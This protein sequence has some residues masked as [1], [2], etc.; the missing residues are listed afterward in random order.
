MNEV[1]D[2]ELKQTKTIAWFT[3]T[4]RYI[5]H[6][7]YDASAFVCHVFF[8]TDTL[9]S[10]AFAVTPP[11]PAEHWSVYIIKIWFCFVK[12]CVSTYPKTS[13][14]ICITTYRP[15][16]GLGQRLLSWVAAIYGL[17]Y[18]LCKEQVNWMNSRWFGMYQFIEVGEKIKIEHESSQTHPN[19]R[20]CPVLKHRWDWQQRE[21]CRLAGTETLMLH[22]EIMKTRWHDVN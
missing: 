18:Q 22:L 1:W 6:N 16:L 17:L 21:V 11:P 4:F 15:I 2:A 10:K 14:C 19:V 3:N 5:F 12:C 7:N 20:L 13:L 8:R 9:C